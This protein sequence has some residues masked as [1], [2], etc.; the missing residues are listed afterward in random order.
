MVLAEAPLK[1]MPAG[2]K[3]P[4]E[5]KEESKKTKICQKPTPHATVF[6]DGAQAWSTV[7]K[8]EWLRCRVEHVSHKY[9]QFTKIVPNGS[10]GSRVAGTQV[11]DRTWDHM[12][13]YIPRTL[14][15]RKLN[16]CTWNNSCLDETLPNIAMAARSVSSWLLPMGSVR[17]AL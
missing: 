8:E 3:P 6:A 1:L 7:I 5:S 12:K 11:I 16:T 17:K 14:S 2:S 13:S 9:G 10:K 15:S 4:P